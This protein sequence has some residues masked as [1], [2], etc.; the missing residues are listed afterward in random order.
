MPRPGRLKLPGAIARALRLEPGERSLAWATD[1]SGRWYVGTDRALYLPDTDGHRRLRWEQV[2]RA[3]WQHDSDVLTVLEIGDEATDGTRTSIE[4]AEPGR[5]L[6]LI[7]ERVTK[8]VVLTSYTPIEGRQGVSVVA[9]RSPTG[10]GPITW[11]YVL[12]RGLDPADPRVVDL[13]ALAQKKA[14]QELGEL[15]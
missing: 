13:V 7:Q 12:S 11:S 1:T 14:E 4:V 8:S 9:R 3:D 10:R 5:L 15:A 2:E 6:E